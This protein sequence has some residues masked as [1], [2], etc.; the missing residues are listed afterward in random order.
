MSLGVVMLR[1]VMLL[2]LLVVAAVVALSLSACAPSGYVLDGFRLHP[3]DECARPETIKKIVTFLNTK[4]GKPDGP[5][6]Q[7]T[8]ASG[9]TRI[10]NRE[11]TGS[12]LTCHGI[13]QTT[14]GMSGPG[15]V[16]LMVLGG[17]GD[18]TAKDASWETDADHD[19]KEA[20]IRATLQAGARRAPVSVAS[21]PART[22]TGEPHNYITSDAVEGAAL[23]LYKAHRSTA[24]DLAASLDGLVVIVYRGCNVSESGICLARGTISSKLNPIGSSNTTTI[25]FN[26]E[27]DIIGYNVATSDGREVAHATVHAETGS[28][29]QQIREDALAGKLIVTP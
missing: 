7:V 2:R 22:N 16:R 13:L 24:S 25:M 26:M 21:S 23:Y 15:A 6:A 8:S 20:A 3:S 11:T 9:F 1:A 4:I 28:V 12:T 18:Y 27:N 17:A 29:L 19:R 10:T 5:T 14:A